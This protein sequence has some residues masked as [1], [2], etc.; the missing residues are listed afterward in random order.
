MENE[1]KSFLKTVGSGEGDRCYY[2]TRLDPYGKGCE[3]NC[4]YCY[5]KSLLA[6]RGLWNAENPAAADINKIKKGIDKLVKN[7]FTG[8][9]RLG[10]MTDC[11]QPKAELKYRNTY[12]TIK[13][14]NE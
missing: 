11:F 10:G 13:Y 5:A 7:G 12:E 8:A 4:K 9:V 1:F 2:P 6:F 3:H 14:L